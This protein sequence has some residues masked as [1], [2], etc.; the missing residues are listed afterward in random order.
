MA[1]KT[2]FILILAALAAIGLTAATGAYFSD[3]E[4]AS[5]NAFS[6]GTLDLS[7]EESEP[8]GADAIGNINWAPGMEFE[9]SIGLRNDG[10]LPIEN[11]SLQAETEISE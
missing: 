2:K 3:R 6:A 11:V 10:S 5:S 9:G 1:M 7:L 8:Q 4:S